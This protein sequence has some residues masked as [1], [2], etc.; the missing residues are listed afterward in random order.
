MLIHADHA[1]HQPLCAWLWCQWCQRPWGV[2]VHFLLYAPALEKHKAGFLPHSLSL[3]LKMEQ[4]C[5]CK[6]GNYKCS[7]EKREMNGFLFC[8]VTLKGRRLSYVWPKVLQ[9]RGKGFSKSDHIKVVNFQLWETPTPHVSDVPRQLQPAAQCVILYGI[10]A[11]QDVLAL[12]G[13]FFMG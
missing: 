1:G 7:G 6:K 12:L 8:F 2:Q 10:K 5:K 11:L 13:G 4:K 3:K 9:L